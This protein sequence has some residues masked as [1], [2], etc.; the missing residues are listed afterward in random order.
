MRRLKSLGIVTFGEY[1]PTTATFILDKKLAN[2]FYTII[3]TS[4]LHG[5][6]Y[7]ITINIEEDHSFSGIMPNGTNPTQGFYFLVNQSALDKVIPSVNSVFGEGDL[8][9]VWKEI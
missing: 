9:E 1:D 5:D 3:A 4:L 2:G 8:I 6:S 7:T